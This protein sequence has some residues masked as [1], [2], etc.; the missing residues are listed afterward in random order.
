MDLRISECPKDNDLSRFSGDMNISALWIRKLLEMMLATGGSSPES[1]RSISSRSLWPSFYISV[2][3]W[4][5][6]F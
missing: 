6:A 4:D 1:D 2:L 3:P 5:E